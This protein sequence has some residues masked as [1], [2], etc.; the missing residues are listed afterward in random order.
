MTR[1]LGI[2]PGS[3]IT[4]YG[5]VE[6]TS[7]GIRYVASGCIR[8]KSDEFPERLKQIFDGVSQVIE[9]YRPEQ[10]AIEQ[11]FMHKNADSALKLGQARGA[12]ICATLN[13]D[14][15]VFEYAARQVKQALVGKGNADKQQVQHMVKI[16]LSIQGDMQIDASDA[17]AIG[18][19]HSHYQET[20]MRLQKAIS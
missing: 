3:R 9:L 7:R 18:L 16:L 14:L 10:M 17:L 5:V 11:V 19:C 12:A 8:I 4:G 1:I 13:R 20:A 6:S 15:P 2:D